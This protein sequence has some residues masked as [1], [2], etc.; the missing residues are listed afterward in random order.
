MAAYKPERGDIIFTDFDPSA[1][2]E[3]ARKRP[4]LVLSP[5]IFN[6]QSGLAL[7]V[8]ITSTVRGNGFETALTKNMKTSGV[9][10]C[11]HVKTIDFH[12]RGFSFI[13]KAP[14]AII[15]DVLSKVQLLIS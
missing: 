10:L 8:P 3:Q 7:V 11:H 6:E 15:S 9:L 13:E 5:K 4:A 1:G 14:K 2:H 12:A